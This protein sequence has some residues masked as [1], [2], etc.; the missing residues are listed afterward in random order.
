[1]RGFA[2]L[3]STRLVLLVLAHVVEHDQS[4]AAFVQH[5]YAYIDQCWRAVQPGRPRYNVDHVFYAHV[6]W[7]ALGA[8]TAARFAVGGNVQHVRDVP[9]HFFLTSKLRKK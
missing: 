7:D 4:V 2:R 3:R 9:L 5:A 8:Q 1:L 6:G